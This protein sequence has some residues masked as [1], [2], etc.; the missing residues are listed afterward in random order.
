MLYGWVLRGLGLGC[1]GQRLSGF[2]CLTSGSR[3]VEET[4]TRQKLVFF[5]FSWFMLIS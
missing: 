2:G 1:R 4:L 5:C 3:V